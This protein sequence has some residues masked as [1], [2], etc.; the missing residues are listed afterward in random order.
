VIVVVTFAAG[1]IP[2]MIIRKINVSEI[3]KTTD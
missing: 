1:V 2:M 3:I